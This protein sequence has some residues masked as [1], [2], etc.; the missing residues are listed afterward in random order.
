ML[1]EVIA[2][3]T[4]V[5]V[6][7]LEK[8]AA[9]AS[10]R[11]R[12]YPI[13]KRTGG[14]RLISHP[15]RTLK[16][17][18]RWLARNLISVA[19]VHDAATAYQKGRSIREN[20]LRHAGSSFTLRLDFREFFPSFDAASIEPFI[21]ET[22]AAAQLQLTAKDMDFVLRILCRN[23]RITIGAPSSPK[24]T[25]AMMFSFDQEMAGYASENNLVYTR[26]ADDLFISSFVPDVLI[27]AEDFVRELALRHRRPALI[28]N[29][30]KT[31]H[32][33]RAGH[34]SVTGMVLTPEG[35][36]SLGRDRKREIKSLVHSATVNKLNPVER[37]RLSGL[38]AFA[39]DVDPDFIGAL[40][41][42]YGIDIVSWA[43]GL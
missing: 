42:K 38:I 40:V 22:A 32:L 29:E 5:P 39:H 10:R 24:I 4:K 25:N 1:I 8:I 28:I 37:A 27:E 15:S 33:S 23:G 43:K 13:P 3:R 16:A 7:T 9:S 31:L 20:A 30:K 35:K 21:A 41:K 26:Y 6:E 11:Y 2:T 14:T 17:L 34:R 12:E 19:P 36:I 18:Q